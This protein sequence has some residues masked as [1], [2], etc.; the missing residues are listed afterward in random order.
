MRYCLVDS[1]S[2]KEKVLNEITIFSQ[3][4]LWQ[5]KVVSFFFKRKWYTNVTFRKCYIGISN[6]T[7]VFLVI[8]YTQEILQLTLLRI[9]LL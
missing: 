1:I 4:F 8:I 3:Y 6:D 9:I 7:K 2:Y 5:D